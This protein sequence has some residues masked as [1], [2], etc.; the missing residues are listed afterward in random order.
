MMRPLQ[1]RYDGLKMLKSLLFYLKTRSIALLTKGITSCKQVAKL[2]SILRKT[3]EITLF[4]ISPYSLAKVSY[5]N[6]Q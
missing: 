2:T 4:F 3:G 1:E 5:A 6:T